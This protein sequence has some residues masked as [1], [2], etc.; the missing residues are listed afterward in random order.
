LLGV[1]AADLFFVLFPWMLTFVWTV[2]SRKGAV[3]Q[4]SDYFFKLFCRSVLVNSI[5]IT[6]SG[7]G[8]FVAFNGSLKHYQ[9]PALIDVDFYRQCI[10]LCRGKETLLQDTMVCIGLFFLLCLIVSGVLSWLFL[11]AH[12]SRVSWRAKKRSTDKLES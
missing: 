3:T 1:Y 9:L 6:A 4:Q 12:E 2:V 5:E 10:R 8:F 7:P 11:L